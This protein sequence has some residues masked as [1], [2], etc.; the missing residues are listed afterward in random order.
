ML[1]SVIR[2][3]KRYYPQIFLEE[4]KYEIIKNEMENFINDDLDLSLFDE[5]DNKFDN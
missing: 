4:A 5:C 1:D 2:A 3:N